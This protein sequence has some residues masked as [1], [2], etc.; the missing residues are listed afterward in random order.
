LH[1]AARVVGP[2]ETVALARQQQGD[3]DV[4]IVLGNIH[5]LTAI[6]PYPRLMLPESIESFARAVNVDERFRAVCVLPLDLDRGQLPRRLLQQLLA[7]EIAVSN[8]AVL[9]RDR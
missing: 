4:G 9:T 1:P 8:A 3:R 5:R 6:V 2:V 7:L